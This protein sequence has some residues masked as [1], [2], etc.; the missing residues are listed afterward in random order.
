[1]RHSTAEL[2]NAWLAALRESRSPPPPPG[3]ALVAWGAT[4]R[5]R[6]HARA[7][8]CTAALGCGPSASRPPH[9]RPL[10][11]LNCESITSRDE[12]CLDLSVD[13]TQNS[14]VTACLRNFR[15]KHAIL[16]FCDACR[17]IPCCCCRPL[18]APCKQGQ[19]ACVN[20]RVRECSR[21]CVRERGRERARARARVLLAP[22]PFAS[23]A[24]SSSCLA[25]RS[26]WE[27]LSG[28]DKFYCDQCC[29][30]QEAQKW[31]AR[32]SCTN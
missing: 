32:Q 27:T 22:C 9:A 6:D 28:A 3:L 12:Q 25:A 11:C 1:M 24:F 21:A 8:G 23:N 18:L 10:R 30:L 5:P 14:S 19:C 31:C 20:A 29:S 7:P 17:T 13:I 15:C 2:F 26:R 4:A 16:F